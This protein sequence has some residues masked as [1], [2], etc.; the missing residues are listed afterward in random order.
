VVAHMPA[1]LPPSK[2]ELAYSNVIRLPD[3][4]PTERAYARQLYECGHVLFIDVAYDNVGY[5]M[6]ISHD[7]ASLTM[8]LVWRSRMTVGQERSW[9][10]TSAQRV[11]V[12]VTVPDRQGLQLQLAARP[13]VVREVAQGRLGDRARADFFLPVNGQRAGVC[14]F[15]EW[16][17]TGIVYTDAGRGVLVFQV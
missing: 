5:T 9:T 6:C 1:N 3:E 4:T 10:R 12:L 14:S 7:Y 13:L 16:T 2:R 8:H 15:D 17:G 11:H